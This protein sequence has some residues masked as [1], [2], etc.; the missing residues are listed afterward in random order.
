MLLERKLSIPRQSSLLLPLSTKGVNTVP[1]RTGQYVPY[2]PVYTI[3]AS[4]SVR[5]TTLFRT[6]KNIGRTGHVSAVPVNFG[7]YWPIPGVPA[8]TEKK[9]LFFIFIIIIF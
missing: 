4:K 7:Q 8:G 9:F 3:P 1:Y 5:L 2:R 6:G